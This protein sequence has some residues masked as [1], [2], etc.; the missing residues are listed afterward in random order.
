MGTHK[1]AQ[2]AVET[3]AA[4]GI[5][6]GT[7]DNT[8]TPGKNITRADFITLLIKALGLKADFNSNFGD[9]TS[10]AYYY[11]AV[12]IAKQLGI[13]SGT[14][15]GNFNPKTEISRQD[16]MVM[17]VKA[18]KASGVKLEG[19]SASDIK[20]FKDAEKVSG[21]ASEAV[22]A[23]IKEGII[24]GSGNSINPKDQLTRAEAAV[25]VYKIY[26]KQ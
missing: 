2:E 1:W 12:G 4:K 19:G 14:S 10:D 7:S 6:S 20:D 25:V 11:Q 26:S 16:M 13:T 5:V 24:K 8:Y 9:V 3:L 17:V 22:A 21:Y 15:D 18:L 23:L